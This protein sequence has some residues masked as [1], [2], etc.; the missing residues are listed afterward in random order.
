MCAL[1][2]GNYDTACVCMRE[3]CFLK[4]PQMLQYRWHDSSGERNKVCGVHAVSCTE[5]S[6]TCGL[7]YI[8]STPGRWFRQHLLLLCAKGNENRLL[9]Q[10]NMTTAWWIR[11]MGT[12]YIDD[13]VF[14]DKYHCGYKKIV[15]SIVSTAIIPE[16]KIASSNW[17]GC[18]GLYLIYLCDV[19][20]QRNM[21]QVLQ[22]SR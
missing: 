20:W 12:I 10:M 1:W 3:M 11:P 6:H 4:C 13:T 18:P 2:L 9:E 19:L 8:W 7:W 22:F 14:H 21:Q 17:G 5:A 15:S 16:C